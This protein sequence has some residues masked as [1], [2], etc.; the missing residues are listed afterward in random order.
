[1]ST[2]S[3][4][5]L[6]PTIRIGP[7]EITRLVIG[8][9]PFSGNSHFSSELD[10]AFLDHF[11]NRQIVETLLHCEAHGLN[12]MQSRADRHI[13]RALREYRNAGGT[14]QWI[15][16]TA[17]E[18]RDIH[19][20]IRQAAAY[21]AIGAY[22]HGSRTDALWREGRIEEVRPYLDTM[23]ECGLLAGVGTH[24]PEVVAHCD[25]HEWNPDFYLTCLY[26]LGSGRGDGAIAGGKAVAESFDDSERDAM[27]QA[28]RATKTPCF[29][30]KILAAGRKC[31][32]EQ[33]VRAAFSYALQG[34]KPTDALIVG[35][36]QQ[37][38]DQVAQNAR[39]VRELC[40]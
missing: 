35:M 25:E 26:P 21:G 30:F 12:T 39:I 3:D 17:S 31:S 14:M 15:G 20:N 11:T 28:I 16:Q 22:H 18:L 27:L 10:E 40:A 8:G 2:D 34:I 5:P 4:R 36:C 23:R 37:H 6:L 1:M 29:A 38:T 24:L 33:D 19:A 32:S 7:C 9:N 13:M